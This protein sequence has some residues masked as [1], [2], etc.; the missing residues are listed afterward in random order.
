[1]SL[2][3]LKRQYKLV[4]VSNVDRASFA[5]SRERLGVEFDRVITAQDV[6]S[7]KPNPRNFEYAI[8]DLHRTFSI[9]KTDVLHIAQ[10]LF[11]DVVPAR[12]LGLSTVWINRRKAV[13]GWGATPPPSAAARPDIEVA[14]LAEFVIL[15]QTQLRASG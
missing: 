2:R 6:G 1:M 3:Y 11:H 8:A 13:G 14:S 5:R 4:I 10:S 9:K 7:Y 15:H 12:K